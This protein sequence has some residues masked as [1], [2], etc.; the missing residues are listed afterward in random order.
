MMDGDWIMLFS[1]VI[2]ICLES[3]QMIDSLEIAAFG[4]EMH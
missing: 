4:L 1:G 3:L 2:G